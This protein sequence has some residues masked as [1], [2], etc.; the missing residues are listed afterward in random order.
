MRSGGPA[1]K[2]L[3]GAPGRLGV[4]TS[5]GGS[6]GRAMELLSELAALPAVGCTNRLKEG[7]ELRTALGLQRVA[8]RTGTGRP[9]EQEADGASAGMS[10]E[11]ALKPLAGVR[12]HLGVVAGSG[13][14]EV[15][16]VELFSWSSLRVVLGSRGQAPLGTH[17]PP[18]PTSPH[19]KCPPS[20]G[21]AMGG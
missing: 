5:G 9:L 21:C 16:G 8:S 15:R 12:K 13:G 6:K 3:G 14:A 2:D 11:P 18:H 10:E 19:P 1:L 17:P 4:V 7:I 20:G